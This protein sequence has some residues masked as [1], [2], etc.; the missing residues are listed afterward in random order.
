[1]FKTNAGS[2][3]C[4][5]E[6]IE[7]MCSRNTF[8]SNFTSTILHFIFTCIFVFNFTILFAQEDEI[9]WGEIPRAD[10]EM[11]AFPDDSNATAV[12]LA[13]I[14][15]V[16]FTDEFNLIFERHRRIKI[17]SEA[18][19]D[20]GSFDIPFYAEKGL[21]RVKKGDVKGHTIF[22]DEYGKEKRVDLEK[23]SIFEE[24]I[25]GQ[26]KR[27]RF[28]LPALKPGCVVEYRYKISSSNPTFLRDW[29]FQTSEPTRWSEFQAEIPD[30]LEYV[31]VW[32]GIGAFDVEESESQPWPHDL[33]Y[34]GTA[35]FYNLR[36]TKHRWCLRNTL[37]LREEPFMTTPEDFRAKIRFQL[38]RINWPN[39]P[40]TE[41]MT[42]WQKLAE[43]LMDS[44][45][46]GREIKRH[47]DLRKQ[48]EKLTAHL[49]DPEEKLRAIYDYV[50]TTMTWNG[51]YGID[52]DKDLDDAYKTRSGAGPEIALILTSMLQ[53][54]GLDAK[55][56]LISTRNHGRVFKQYPMLSQ[57]NYVLTYVK[58]GDRDHL[59]DATDP[60]RPMNILPV[61]ALNECGFLVDEKNPMLRQR[62]MKMALSMAGSIR[63]MMAIVAFLIGKLCVTKKKKH[64]S[65]M[66]G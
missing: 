29:A 60:L 44:R 30:P 19:Y 31:M 58:I 53:F 35:D 38:A 59:L 62:S 20:W 51:E 5:R 49:T 9:K 18:G 10:L 48:A 12:I 3:F 40:Y 17:L 39:Q 47:K 54:A 33:I 26:Y 34:S 27:V 21:Q 52:I 66:A 24:D 28:T 11:T 42:S 25:D 23:E 61:D 4:K 13:D 41:V 64:I 7:A 16:R 8:I 63:Q 55:P 1:M 50:Q 36:V 43:E 6:Q 65:A 37:A 2:R 46:F 14:G 57:F 15:R 32:Q 56:V 45:Y 22:L